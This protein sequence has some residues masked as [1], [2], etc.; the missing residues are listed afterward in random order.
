MMLRCCNSVPFSACFFAFH[1]AL[2]SLTR[3]CCAFLNGVPHHQANALA[4][5]GRCRANSC[6]TSALSATI[7][8]KTAPETAGDAAK[9]QP[10]TKS[11]AKSTTGLTRGPA[12]KIVVKEED[13]RKTARWGVAPTA[14]AGRQNPLKAV[15]SSI[16]AVGQGVT[17][18]K[19]ALY[20]VAET[21]SSLAELAQQQQPQS[22]STTGKQSSQQ[23]RPGSA[24]VG[25]G[26]DGGG[27]GEGVSAVGGVL[28][29]VGG[30]AVFVKDAIW[31]SIEVLGEVADAARAAPETAK[32]AAES[33][34]AVLEGEWNTIGRRAYNI[35]NSVVLLIPVCAVMLL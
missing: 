10:M 20:G 12:S 15:T 31:G 29:A 11:A 6:T 9:K 22:S 1:V 35:V 7:G 33:G 34:K 28:K 17:A 25:D 2:L 26:G 5:S 4:I 19:D 30:G 18:A 27:L 24:V 3:P 8:G 21:A 14:P 16:S 13:E 23:K 32:S